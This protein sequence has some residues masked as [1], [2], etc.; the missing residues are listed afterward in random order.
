[1][2]KSRRMPTV[3]LSTGQ[4]EEMVAQVLRPFGINIDH[5]L[6]LMREAQSLDYV[7]S[8]SIAGIGDFLQRTAVRAVVV[9]GD[10]SSTLGASLAAFH[11]D[12]PVAHVE[13]GLRSHNITIPFPEE[14]NRRLTS[15]LARWHFAPTKGAAENLRM[16]GITEGVH[17]TGNTVVDAVRHILE[18]PVPLPEQLRSFVTKGPV[19]VATAHRRESW[20]GGIERVARA[21]RTVLSEFQEYR[22][23]FAT[24]P[25][26]LARQPVETIFRDEPRALVVQALEYPS[27][28]RVL[29]QATL[30]VTDS[31]GIQEEGPT[32]G[33][34][35]MVTRDVTERPEGVE[36]GAVR[37]VGTDETTILEGARELLVD[38]AARHAMAAVGRALYGDGRAA[39]RIVEV[40]NSEA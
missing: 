3:V 38:H 8:A 11:A 28:I 35:V 18:E 10:T 34:P 31:G 16:E 7:L 19:I 6:H 24:H 30:A 27:F 33:V 36:A 25:N 37:L 39:G 14:M 29:S 22:L 20:N 15:Q 40:L 17:I 23:V 9:Q 13:A 5:D 12:A 2:L 32:L 1:M 26:P 21:L 4:H